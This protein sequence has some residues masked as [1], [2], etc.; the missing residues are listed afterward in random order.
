MAT[1][2]PVVVTNDPDMTQRILTSPD[3]L[4]KAFL[5]KFFRLDSG[6]FAANYDLWKAQRKAIN[7]TF[8]L[9]ILHKFIPLFDKYAQ[10]LVQ[11][12]GAF[13]DGRALNLSP[14]MHRCS[15]KT[16]CATTM[17]VVID[18]DSDA[19]R[20]AELLQKTFHL[21]FKR[22]F[23]VHWHV[24]WMYR[25]TKDYKKDE[26]IREEI[27]KYGDEIM[28]KAAERHSRRMN[29]FKREDDDCCKL[30]IF[31]DQMLNTNSGKKFSDIEINH[32]FYT[33]IV[34]G[35]DTTGIFLGYIAIA[36][37]ANQD[38]Q[39]KVYQE[40]CTVY[41]RNKEVIFT[42]ESLNQLLYTDMF[43]KE[44]LRLFP[45]VPMVVRKTLRDVDLNGFQ[46]PKGNI[47]IV[48]IYNLHRRKDIW[49]PNANR[50]DPENFSAERCAGRHPYAFI[51]FSG[52]NRNCLGYR[53]AMIN[54]KI[55]VVHLLRTFK[56][57][58]DWRLE[59]LRFRFEA[60]L[61]TAAD[62]EIRLVRR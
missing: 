48:S 22:L 59:D 15:M 51:P 31:M 21:A 6:L 25:L 47:L 14:F 40:I 18:E 44:C 56:L 49:G 45:V 12:L 38:I 32:N 1:V 7:P 62:P 34:G 29:L 54:M 61:K 11:T 55:V 26:K 58:S 5:Y 43:L 24:D 2:M 10:E 33:M 13:A 3:C 46:V 57:T 37:A 19:D 35:S 23:H 17:G 39:E 50:F 16:I 53:Y 20:F 27:Y 8:N 4:E 28:R 41:P 42:P 52:G 30:Q 36:L 9:K 60:L